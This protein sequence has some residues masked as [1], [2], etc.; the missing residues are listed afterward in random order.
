[1]TTKLPTQGSNSENHSFSSSPVNQLLENQNAQDTLTENLPV[2]DSSITYR[3]THA[4]P[5]SKHY[6]NCQHGTC[7]RGQYTDTCPK[8][9][10]VISTVKLKTFYFS[11]AF[12]YDVSYCAV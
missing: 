11:N 6:R 1:M 9:Q 12:L 10:E 3:V 7:A 5:S 2:V 8:Q 4:G